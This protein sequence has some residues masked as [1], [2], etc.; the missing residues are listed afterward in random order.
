MHTVAI[1]ALSLLIGASQV[2]PAAS[3]TVAAPR[4]LCLTSAVAIRLHDAVTQMVTASDP[5]ERARVADYGLRRVPAEAVQIIRSPALCARAARAY[6][7][8]SSRRTVRPSRLCAQASATSYTTRLPI[9]E[10]SGRPYSSSP[11]ASAISRATERERRCAPANVTLQLTGYGEHQVVPS[12]T[13]SH[14]QA[15]HARRF[16]AGS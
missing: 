4:T 8:Q 15:R 10:A 11:A 13:P 2:L 16:R 14:N 9:R 6:A 12:P 5:D 3:D 7:A 1:L